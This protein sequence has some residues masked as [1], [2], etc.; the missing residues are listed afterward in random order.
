M[1][2]ALLAFAAA[3]MM[4]GS[5]NA[6]YLIGEP[7]G[8]WS[9][10]VGIEMAEVE[11][12]WQ[13]KGSISTDTYFAFATNLID[14]EDWGTFNSTYRLSPDANGTQAVEGEYALHLGGQ[15]AAFRGC[16]TE[17][18]LT[19]LKTGD[20]YKLNVA[21]HGEVIPPV[22]EDETWGLIGDF[23]SWGADEAMTELSGGIWTVNI[24]EINGGFKFRKN[25]RWD[26]DFGG[27]GPFTVENNGQYPIA[28]GG[29]NFNIT[30]GK[31]VTM[32]LDLN[33][34]LLTTKFNVGA[35]THLALRG[36]VNSWGWEPM[37]CFTET[38]AEGIYT[39]TVP[40]IESGSELKIAN[41]NWSVQY[42]TQKIDMVANQEYELTV[43]DGSSSN[44][45]FAQ[46]YANVVLTIDTN[47]NT[48]KATATVTG[49]S[50]V[51]AA[52][53]EAVYFNLQGVKVANPVGGLYI[54]VSGN[55]AEKVFVK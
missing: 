19:V 29:N 24:A 7:A 34:R 13:W 50:Q 45:A 52:S 4:A 20:T 49:I 30:D 43:N 25:G 36:D 53:Q 6:M 55:K 33:S 16:G 22:E 35:A 27:D 14:T 9:P 10:T 23:N 26:V 38:E 15:D 18:T 51:E 8:N 41:D 48:F 39:L 2:K 5:A 17:C 44:M 42:T 47:K 54:R 46:S 32:F 21:V 37:Y 12:G 31:N 3:A 1:K 40:A 11:G 28:Q